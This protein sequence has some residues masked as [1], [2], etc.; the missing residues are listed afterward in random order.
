MVTIVVGGPL[1]EMV[2]IEFHSSALSLAHWCLQ[3]SPL[4]A[5]YNRMMNKDGLEFGV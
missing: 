2:F 4:A 3:S 5:K 1:H